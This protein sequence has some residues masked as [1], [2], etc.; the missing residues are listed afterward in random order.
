MGTITYPPSI[1]SER[2]VR[3]SMTPRGDVRHEIDSGAVHFWC[4]HCGTNH[5]SRLIAA[6][7]VRLLVNGPD[8]GFGS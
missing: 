6:E 1:T 8:P 7:C 4:D 2:C 3:T 5:R